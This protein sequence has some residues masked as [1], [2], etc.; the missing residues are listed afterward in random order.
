MPAGF[1][2]DNQSLP[3]PQFP[4]L[5]PLSCYTVFWSFSQP[6]PP[7]NEN[8]GDAAPS[9][10]ESAATFN[11]TGMPSTGFKRSRLH[12]GP[13]EGRTTAGTGQAEEGHLGLDFRSR[14]AKSAPREASLARRQRE[15]RRNTP[16]GVTK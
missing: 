8:L 14:A 1:I 10:N 5:P 11:P 12:E 7:K 9:P 15:R 2:A 13:E 4:P 6:R 3:L 16:A